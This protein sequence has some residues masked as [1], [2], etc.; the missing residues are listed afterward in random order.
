V[1][2]HGDS[3]E[4]RTQE[5]LKGQISSEERNEVVVILTDLLL[6]AVDEFHT[7][8]M[9]ASVTN[10]NEQGQGQAAYE[11]KS[12]PAPKSDAH[13]GEEICGM[14]DLFKTCVERCPSYFFQLPSAPGL[15]GQ[16]DLLHLKATESTIALLQ[17]SD[18]Q[19]SKH[20]MG[21]LEAL[22][23]LTQSQN[24]SVR[25]FVLE[26]VSRF[27][28]GILS[29]LL[30]GC[31]GQ[32]SYACLG[33]AAH[34][35]RSVVRSTPPTQELR[36]SAIETLKNEQFR[37]GDEARQIV[38]NALEGVVRNEVSV[39]GLALL[40]GQTWELHQ[41]DEVESLESSDVVKRFVKRFIR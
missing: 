41:L 12:V 36:T 34:L 13:V 35:L 27:Q 2:D 40:L 18:T 5:A 3:V 10:A 7:A 14:L 26:T 19:T 1:N 30:L 24:E 33:D 15:E 28:P 38:F 22:L 32:M 37:L 29:T 31:C 6:A 8:S 21:Y 23:K 25:N 16:K 20:A 9:T 11:S 39:E 4:I 17:E